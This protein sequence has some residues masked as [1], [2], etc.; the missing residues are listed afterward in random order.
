MDELIERV[1]KV[2]HERD[3]YRQLYLDTLER[4]RMLEVARRLA[5][6]ALLFRWF[7]SSKTV[8]PLGVVI[9]S[10]GQSREKIGLC[11]ALRSLT[12]L[13]ICPRC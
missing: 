2:E 1:E 7:T 10:S 8:R 9:V 12:W 4:C 5:A 3:R 13:R 11:L 6:V